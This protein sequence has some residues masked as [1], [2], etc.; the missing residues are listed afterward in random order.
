MKR[1]TG[2]FKG[3]LGQATLVVMLVFGL[4]LTACP[5]EGDVNGGGAT[6]Y[7]VTFDAQ[8]GSVSPSTIT[9]NAGGTIAV[10]PVPTRNG[11]TFGGWFTVNIQAGGINL[12][13]TSTPVYGDITVFPLWESESGGDPFVGEWTG[14]IT[15][16]YSGSEYAEVSVANSS[17]AL[18]WGLDEPPVIGMYA[19]DGGN[20][21]TLFDSFGVPFGSA[22]ITIETSVLQLELTGGIYNGYSGEFTRSSPPAY[23]YTVTFDAQGG[24]A[25]QSTVFV[26]A[27]GYITNL[28][29]ATRSGYTFGGWFTQINGGGAPFTGST[30]VYSNLTVYA[31]WTS[32]GG[33]T[34]E[35][36]VYIGIISFAGDATDLFQK[37]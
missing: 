33:N 12:F 13:T 27:G 7:T 1:K 22:Y 3:I 19:Y 30:P 8:G 20:S 24:F 34:G 9:V 6:T 5:T 26:N 10:L 16:P 2:F 21:A 35:E 18:S 14:F 36:G 15:I 32:G 17:W 4:L 11:Y 37:F 31:K 25:S 29:V 28:P 23:Q